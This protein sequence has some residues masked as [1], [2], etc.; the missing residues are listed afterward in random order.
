MNVEEAKK[1]LEDSKRFVES[2]KFEPEELLADIDEC[3]SDSRFKAVKDYMILLSTYLAISLIVLKLGGRTYR[4][5]FIAGLIL[6][7]LF[8]W[9]SPSTRLNWTYFKK[10]KYTVLNTVS[11]FEVMRDNKDNDWTATH[12]A[13]IMIQEKIMSDLKLLTL[14]V[15]VITANDL[16]KKLTDFYRYLSCECFVIGME[17]DIDRVNKNQTDNSKCLKNEYN[18]LAKEF[19]VDKKEEKEDE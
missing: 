3:L 7:T 15:E 17:S 11:L 10:L 12:L 8:H 18:N 19:G 16:Q 9:L 2:Y 1:K 14:G 4:I 6:I 13:I 5:S